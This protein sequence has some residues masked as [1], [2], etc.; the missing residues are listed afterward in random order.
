SGCRPAPPGPSLTGSSPATPPQACSAAGGC[1]EPS[2]GPSTEPCLNSYRGW[3]PRGQLIL[4]L[5]TEAKKALSTSAFSSSS[6]AQFL[7]CLSKKPMRISICML[8]G[9]TTPICIQLNTMT[10]KY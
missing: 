5:K 7:L 10:C 8:Y 6:R 1:C 3:V 9:K 2:T 4:L